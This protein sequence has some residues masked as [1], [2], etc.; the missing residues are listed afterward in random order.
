MIFD[1]GRGT[2]VGEA[3]NADEFPRG[4]VEPDQGAIRPSQARGK[5]GSQNI[6]GRSEGDIGGMFRQGRTERLTEAAEELLVVDLGNVDLGNVDFGGAGYQDGIRFR[7]LEKAEADRSASQ[8]TG[9]AK[10]EVARE[11]GQMQ[12]VVK[13]ESNRDQSLGAAAVLLGLVQVT[14]KFESD[15]NLRRQSAGAADVFVADRPRFGAVEYS[16][17]PEHLAV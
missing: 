6:V 16:K 1:G 4:A 11:L 10:S 14:G 2:A 9:G 12:D 17:H 3:K 15:G 13:F 5:I 8:Q 7:C